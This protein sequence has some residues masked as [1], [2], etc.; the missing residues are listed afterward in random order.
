MKKHAIKY[1]PSYLTL[2]LG[3]GV[4]LDVTTTHERWTAERPSPSLAEQI[5]KTP[6]QLVARWQ[7]NQQINWQS[8]NPIQNS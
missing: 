6:A 3:L 1:T 4:N 2:M 5:K 8:N 7:K